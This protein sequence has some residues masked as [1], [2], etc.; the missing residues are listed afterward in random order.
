MRPK[1]SVSGNPESVSRVLTADTPLL[2]QDQERSWVPQDYPPSTF[3]LCH[4]LDALQQ[5]S[6][7]RKSESELRT[8][9]QFQLCRCG[10]AA[11]LDAIRYL[12]RW[13]LEER[14][15][16]RHNGRRGHFRRMKGYQ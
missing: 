9:L 4:I 8:R 11:S 12:L 14:A 15:M 7:A 10:S 16:R 5:S 3:T 2:A 6:G 1:P 13:K